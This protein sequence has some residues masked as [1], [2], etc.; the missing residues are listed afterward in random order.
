MQQITK[1]G[2]KVLDVYTGWEIPKQ[3]GMGVKTGICFDGNIITFKRRKNINFSNCLIAY[4]FLLDYAF[5][6]EVFIYGK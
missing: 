3:S 2:Y 6:Q 4:I 5:V 1:C